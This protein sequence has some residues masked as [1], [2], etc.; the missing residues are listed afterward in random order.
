MW[1]LAL[2]KVRIILC[3]RLALILH[4]KKRQAPSNDDTQKTDPED[5]PG[6]YVENILDESFT[7]H[8]EPPLPNTRALSDPIL[9][10]IRDLLQ[11]KALKEEEE[12]TRKKREDKMKQEWM[13]A[14]RVFNRL[15]FVFFTVAL[16]VVTVFLFY[17][18]YSHTSHRYRIWIAV[19]KSFL[20]VQ[21][22]QFYTISVRY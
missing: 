7:N 21:F 10:D 3:E 16:L 9:I 1:F 22:Q 6:N 17:I 8:I 18:I 19:Y 11:R 15:C 12:L 20:S 4:V 14:A 2:S 13:L 5:F